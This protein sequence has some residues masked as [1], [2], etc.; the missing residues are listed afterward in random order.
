MFSASASC[1]GG[2]R[3]NRSGW[4]AACICPRLPNW[5]SPG[6]DGVSPAAICPD[7]ESRLRKL[8]EKHC[9]QS[10]AQTMKAACG[11]WR[12]STATN[13]RLHKKGISA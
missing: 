1:D 9:H 4:D 12:K 2:L 3:R 13:F 8:A 6:D 7:H 10:P 5:I 11:S